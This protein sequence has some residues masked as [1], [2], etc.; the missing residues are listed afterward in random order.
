MFNQA[1]QRAWLL[2]GQQVTTTIDSVQM[3]C[4]VRVQRDRLSCDS[5]R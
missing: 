1:G 4:G 3:C 2:W 5:E